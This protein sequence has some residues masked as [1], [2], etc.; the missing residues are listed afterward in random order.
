MICICTAAQHHHTYHHY[1]E[2]MVM[3]LYYFELQSNEEST[4]YSGKLE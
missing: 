2:M 1:G 3:N 4:H